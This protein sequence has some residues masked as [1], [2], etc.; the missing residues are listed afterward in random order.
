MSKIK[1]SLMMIP[2]LMLCINFAEAQQLSLKE[3]LQYALENNRNIAISKYSEMAGEEKV[4]ETRALALPQVNANANLTDNLKRQVLV[5]PAEFVGGET[6]TFTTIMAGTKY[7]AGASAE[8]TQQ[9]FNQSVF[10]GLKAAK[11][12]RDYYAVNTQ[13]TEEEVINQVAHAYYSVLITREQIGFQNTN[14]KNLEQLVTTTQAQFELGLSRKIDLD[15]IKVNLTNS[16]TRL[17]SLQN[18][19][20]IQ[21]NQLK[22]LMGMPIKSDLALKNVPL[23]SL[24]ETATGSIAAEPFNPDNLLQVKTLN[25]QERL[26]QYQKK[27]SIAEYYPKLSLFANYSYNSV[28]NNFD[29][30]KKDGTNISYDMAAVGIRLTVPIFDG[31]ARRARVAQSSIDLYKLDK[32]RE[33]TVLQLNTVYESARIQMINS[34]NTINLQKE[35]MQLAGEVYHSSKQ[36]FD[37]GLATLTD[38]LNAETSLVE[39]Q[40]SYAQALLNYQVAHIE[41]IKATG[42]TQ[43]LLQ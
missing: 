5:L 14:I 38:L 11:A 21:S 40:N 8:A 18:Q 6:G 3:C 4:K 15:R 9:V 43:S 19:L 17:T 23:D 37:L 34:I 35:N 29:F 27:A 39:A 10:T 22:L 16:K 28:S 13:L 7:S 42:R 26:Y 31:F 12:S 24:E 2:A 41:M 36:N 33:N 32:E 30:L 25:V 20:D 1:Q